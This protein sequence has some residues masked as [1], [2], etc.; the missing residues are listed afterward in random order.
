MLEVTCVRLITS[1]YQLFYYNNTDFSYA[2]VL[3]S[4]LP[5]IVQYRYL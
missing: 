4:L 2:S 3:F 1:I 5:T